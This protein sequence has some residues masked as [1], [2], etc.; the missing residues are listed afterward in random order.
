MKKFGL[1]LLGCLTLSL[2]QAQS[3]RFEQDTLFVK[4]KAGEELPASALIKDSKH[5]FGTVYQITTDHVILLENDLRSNAAVEYTEKSFFAGKQ[6]L[7]LPGNAIPASKAVFAGFNDPQ[8]NKVWA[9]Q[10]ATRNGVSVIK[11][12]GELPGG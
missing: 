7:A 2:A 6:K 9:F 4:L 3:I 8:A 10:D 5:L 1:A 12:Y 11:A